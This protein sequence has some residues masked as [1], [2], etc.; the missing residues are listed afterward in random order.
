VPV[1]INNANM[2]LPAVWIHGNA[3]ARDWLSS[4]TALYIIDQ[5]GLYERWRR[6][7]WAL[8]CTGSASLK[9]W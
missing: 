9:T 8:H 5:V 1:Q 7:K 4:A 2:N 3:N 6:I